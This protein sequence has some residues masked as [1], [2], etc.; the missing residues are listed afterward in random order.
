MIFII[1]INFI[2]IGYSGYIPGVKSENLF[3]KTY[4]KVTTLSKDKSHHRGVDLPTDLRYTS[5]LF[6]EY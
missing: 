1:V 4:G 6:E 3:G 5:T 2:I